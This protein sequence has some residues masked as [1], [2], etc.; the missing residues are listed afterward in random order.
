MSMENYAGLQEEIKS[1]LWDRAD[2]VA[3]IPTFITLAESEIRRLIR[4][5]QTNA[6][7]SF[8]AGPGVAA[9]PCGAGAILAVRLNDGDAQTRDLD[10]VSPENFSAQSPSSGRPRFYTV[11]DGHIQLYPAGSDGVSG[12]IVF[13]DAFEPLSRTCDCNWLLKRHPDIYLCGALKWGKAWLI[14]ADWD[15]ATPFYSAIEAANHDMPRVSSSTRLRANE[16]SMMPQKG[17]FDM[18]T[19]GMEGPPPIIEQM[20][21]A[22]NTPPVPFDYAS[23]ITD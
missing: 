23:E 14:D 20:F 11:I 8:S 5:R 7:R 22:V 4:T 1:F 16:V 19:G 18:I 21:I 17:G 6:R 2:V 12:E 15:W 3:K 10:Y 9:I 13:V